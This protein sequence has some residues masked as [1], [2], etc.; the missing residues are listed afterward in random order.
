MVAANGGQ[1]PAE[2]YVRRNFGGGKGVALKI[3]Q[4]WRG[5]GEWDAEESEN[6]AGSYGSQDSRM[7]TGDAQ[8]GE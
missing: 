4:E 3:W 1:K 2:C 6:G 5:G 8:V 7:E